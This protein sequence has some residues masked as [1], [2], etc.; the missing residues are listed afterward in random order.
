M[1]LVEERDPV[2]P[3]IAACV[4][5]GLNRATLYRHREPAP[6]APSSTAARSRPTNPRRLADE[7]RQR[8]LDTLH[9]PEFADQPPSEV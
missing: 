5:V 1:A 4:A 8:I 6:A 7:E 2:V 3:I 9:A